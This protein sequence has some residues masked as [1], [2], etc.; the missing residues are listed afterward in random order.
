VTKAPIVEFLPTLRNE[1]HIINWLSFRL[2][3]WEPRIR[4]AFSSLPN[5]NTNGMVVIAKGS[6]WSAGGVR[7]LEKRVRTLAKDQKITVRIM[8]T[9]DVVGLELWDES[10]FEDALRRLNEDAAAALE[11]FKARRPRVEREQQETCALIARELN[12]FKYQYG[13]GKT[14]FVVA[15][16]DSVLVRHLEPRA[17][18][19]PQ[20]PDFFDEVA[21]HGMITCLVKAGLIIT[22]S[23]FIEGS[24]GLLSWRCELRIFA[25]HLGSRITPSWRKILIL[26]RRS[27]TCPRLSH[28]MNIN[29]MALNL[30]AAAITVW[31]RAC[32]QNISNALRDHGL[33]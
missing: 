15:S 27:A 32:G 17:R 13:R 10:G 8:R 2:Y 25:E 9:M 23:A 20:T 12:L 24:M 7:A 22:L 14:D 19:S 28:H 5:H 18:P 31:N 3:A 1:A 30:V 29:A 26:V 4:V 33:L 16:P 11:R 6:P 21:S